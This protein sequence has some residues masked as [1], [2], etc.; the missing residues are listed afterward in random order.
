MKKLILKYNPR[1]GNNQ[2]PAIEKMALELNCKI[3]HAHIDETSKI[4]IVTVTGSQQSLAEMNER[5][6]RHASIDRKVA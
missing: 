1:L 5:L 3:E 2:M 6:I 4:I